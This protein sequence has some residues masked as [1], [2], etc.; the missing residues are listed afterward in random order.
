MLQAKR[1]SWLFYLRRGAYRRNSGIGWYYL[2]SALL[3]A[4][5][6]TAGGFLLWSSCAFALTPALLLPVALW[7][8]AL[9]AL[10]AGTG[11]V[12]L[13]VALRQ[14]YIQGVCQL[15]N[16]Q[17]LRLRDLSLE[18]YIT[19][20]NIAKSALGCFMIVLLGLVP[21]LCLP[22]VWQMDSPMLSAVLT[23][24]LIVLS[25]AGLGVSILAGVFLVIG[26]IGACSVFRQMGKFQ[27]YT[28]NHRLNIAVTNS[29]MTVCSPGKAETL[30]DLQVLDFSDRRLLQL[31]LCDY[32]HIAAPLEEFETAD[33]VPGIAV[34]QVD[35]TAALIS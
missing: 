20:V 27:S 25:V 12:R 24:M 18:N 32:W 3:I 8:I 1:E 7:G 22:S 21:V 15:E 11:F 35:Q 13:L 6:A 33:L 19:I 9:I 28:L 5:S 10:V 23:V 17:L 4:I 2:G 30:F 34:Q 29:T 14:G 31:S 26:L 16:G